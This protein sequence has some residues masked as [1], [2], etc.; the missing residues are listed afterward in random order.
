MSWTIASIPF[1]F[2]GTLF[3]ILG[4]YGIGAVSF[5]EGPTQRF[6]SAP[7]HECIRMCLIM[8]LFSC[9]MMFIA[10]KIASGT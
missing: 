2:L 9:V 6:K 8:I 7:D 5:H 1:W 3:F 10:A 4:I